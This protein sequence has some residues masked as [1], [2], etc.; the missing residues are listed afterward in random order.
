MFEVHVLNSAGI[1]NAKLL[2]RL[3][4]NFLEEIETISGKEGR[5]IAIVRTK[6]EEASFY[7]KKAMAMKPENQ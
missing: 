4:Q 3:F 2:Q 1:S 6:L 5:E 7:A